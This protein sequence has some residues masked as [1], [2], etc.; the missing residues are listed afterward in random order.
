MKPLNLYMDISRL[1]LN[2]TKTMFLPHNTLHPHNTT[3]SILKHNY[4]QTF[5]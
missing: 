1:H 3:C 4:P 5:Y 2:K